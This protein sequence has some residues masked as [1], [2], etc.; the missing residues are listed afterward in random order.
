MPRKTPTP[1]EVSGQA[2]DGLARLVRNLLV[3]NPNF[4]PGAGGAEP[5]YFR[6]VPRTGGFVTGELRRMAEAIIERIE[7]EREL[8]V[9]MA[10]DPEIPGLVRSYTGRFHDRDLRLSPLDDGTW[11]VTIVD[12]HA[13]HGG[14]D[15]AAIVPDEAA[16]LAAARAFAATGEVPDALRQPATPAP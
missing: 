5:H 16:A 4:R 14:E 1:S 15:V 13:F 6:T 9:A 11:S 8:V 7:R 10:A 12:P 3:D 2:M